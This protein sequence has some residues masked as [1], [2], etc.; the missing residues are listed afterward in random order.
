MICTNVN[1]KTRDVHFQSAPGEGSISLSDGDDLMRIG[2]YDFSAANVT[3]GSY[4]CIQGIHGMVKSSGQFPGAP[5]GVNVEDYSELQGFVD[6][7][8]SSLQAPTPELIAEYL[9]WIDTGGSE[10]PSMIVSE[11]S[12]QTVY[13]QYE[14]AN[15]H[16]V[17]V[18]QGQAVSP[19]GGV[20]APMFSHGGK[21]FVWPTSRACKPNT[22][23]GMDPGSLVRFM[24]IGDGSLRWKIGSGPTA[25]LGT[26]FRPV[27]TDGGVRMT[28]VSEAPYNAYGQLGINKPNMFFIIQGVQSQRDV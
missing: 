10:L 11:R 24:P 28:K 22:I 19:N 18:P 5:S 13:S 23:Y 17:L 20:R 21:A 8:Y 12:V 25:G 3:A 26:M 2:V 27:L 1:K 14:K 15:S 9:D 7:D 16:V 6:G 4:K